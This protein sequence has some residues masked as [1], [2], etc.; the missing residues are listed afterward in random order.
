MVLSTNSGYCLLISNLLFHSALQI[1]MLLLLMMT[2]TAMYNVVQAED[3]N[4]ESLDVA[5][6]DLV[7]SRHV[8]S[9]SRAS[10]GL[11]AGS[12]V[13]SEAAASVGSGSLM[14]ERVVRSPL[15]AG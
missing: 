12:S 6:D 5:G 2:T 7:E 15:H 8:S 3:V 10:R 13:Y 14:S 11:Y 4:D 9:Q 1:F